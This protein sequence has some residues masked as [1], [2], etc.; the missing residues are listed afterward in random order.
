MQQYRDFDAGTSDKLIKR[1]LNETG[2]IRTINDSHRK[3]TGPTAG[4]LL[5]HTFSAKNP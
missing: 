2:R 1:E 3:I 4:N 5:S